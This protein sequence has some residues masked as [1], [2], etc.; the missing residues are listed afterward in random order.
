MTSRNV[1]VYATKNKIFQFLSESIT[2]NLFVDAITTLNPIQLGIEDAIK[3]KF[4]SLY[5][6][7][8]T[9]VILK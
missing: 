6:E 1:F 8:N 3:I 7:I 5:S 4:H 2:D 9:K